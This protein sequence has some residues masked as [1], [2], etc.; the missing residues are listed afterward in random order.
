MNIE[1]K[2]II[3]AVVGLL[4]W[5]WGIVQFILTRRNQKRDKALEKRF[6]VYS[7]FMNKADEINQNIRTDPK[8][9]YGIKTEFFS[10][11]ITGNEEEINKALVDFNTEIIEITRKYVQQKMILNKELNKLK[12]VCSNKLLPKIE[13]Y[14]QITNDYLNEIQNVLNNI[15]QDK[16]I[17]IIAKQ[18]ETI[19]H[20][21]KADMMD[22]LWKEIEKM[23]RDEIGYYK[24]K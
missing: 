8:M 15:S 19:G 10:K 18:L 1:A 14:K 2:D 23:M 3:F 13:Q 5:I 9:I 17:N 20:S 16:D 24:Q 6:E 12:L 7:E 4:G 21:N 11:I 22:D